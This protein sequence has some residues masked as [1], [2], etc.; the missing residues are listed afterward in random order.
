M[1]ETPRASASSNAW[2]STTSAARRTGCRSPASPR[3]RPPRLRTSKGECEANRSRPQGHRRL[4]GAHPCARERVP[5]GARHPLVSGPAA[6]AR[7]GQPGPDAVPARPRPDRPLQGVQAAQTQ[8]AGVRGAGGG[9][10]PDPAY[11]HA[12]GLLHLPDGGASSRPERGSDRGDRAGARSGASA[13]RPH[14]R[15]GAG[16]GAAGARSALSPQRA[17]AAGGGRAGAGWPGPQPDR[18][19]ARRDPE[20]HRAG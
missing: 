15:G 2:G 9:P 10:L 3:L 17:L 20:P 19:G 4:R 18:A 7:G 16:R 8:D 14:R 1:A 13:L 12:G 5:L 11:P 6:G